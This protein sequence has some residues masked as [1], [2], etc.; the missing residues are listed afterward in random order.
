V[1]KDNYL[2]KLYESSH[3][4]ASV[5]EISRALEKS[6]VFTEYA[7]WR[8]GT[9]AEITI[10]KLGD[11]FKVKVEYDYK[12]ECICPTLERAIGMAGLY[13]GLIIKLDQ[14]VGWPSN[15]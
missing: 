8:M 11:K 4:E 3:L 2:K 1:F 6:D 7:E 13:I 10:S 9:C 5:Q 14:Q 12:F 15:A